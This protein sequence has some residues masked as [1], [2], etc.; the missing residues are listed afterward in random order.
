M[1]WYADLA[2]TLNET[3][4][5]VDDWMHQSQIYARCY[6]YYAGV[7]L[8]ERSSKP[9]TDEPPLLYPVRLNLVKMLCHTQA[10]ALW[11]E[12]D[13]RMATFIVDPGRVKDGITDEDMALAGALKRHLD[14]VYDIAAMNRILWESGLD[15]SRYGGSVLKIAPAPQGLTGIRIERIPVQSFLP[16][17]NPDDLD[18]LLE[19]YVVTQ[20]NQRVAKLRYGID[21]D[22]QFVLR[23]EHWT[24]ATYET[25][26]DNKVISKYSGKNP[27]GII[28][29][30]YTPRLRSDSYFGEPLIDD[31]YGVQDELN[32]RV[33]DIGDALNY[34]THPLRW[35]YNLPSDI[36]NPQKY[37]YGPDQLWDLGRVLAGQEPPHLE[38]LELKHPVPDAAFK[39]IDFVYDWGRHAS[40]APPIVF[41]VD[42]GSQR[43][44]ATLTIRFWQ[45]VRAVKRSRIYNRAALSRMIE[46]VMAITEKNFPSKFDK[47]LFKT[48]RDFGTIVEFSPILP[49]DRTEIVDEMVKRFSTSPP[50][51]SL[52]RA[53]EELGE[54]DPVG[55]EKRIWNDRKAAQ[56]SMVRIQEKEPDED[57][58]AD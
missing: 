43:S 25:R 16:V 35:G 27:W 29:L 39:Y 12:W 36:D 1:H 8:S 37:P 44:G 32:S 15:Q 17:W 21:T 24:K 10:D 54:R 49:R 41:G 19:A 23:V 51:V 57:S 9:D 40:Y 7:Q 22:R 47:S 45:L 34:N 56:E 11:G 46:I 14:R 28:P 58:V 13:E 33:A 30:V 3:D 53:L 5:P 52:A 42:E 4:A 18:D 6:R 2:N 48:Y 26:I 55:E 50:S 31:I 20:I 38:A